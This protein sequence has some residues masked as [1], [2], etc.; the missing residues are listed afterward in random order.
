[1]SPIQSVPTQTTAAGDPAADRRLNPAITTAG[2]DYL[3]SI[4]HFAGPAANAI[5][6]RTAFGARTYGD[7]AAHRPMRELIGEQI[8][9]ADDINGW[10]IWPA[11]IAASI[12]SSDERYGHGR[13]L[14]DQ[15]VAI[16]R[17]AVELRQM[18]TRAARH[19]E[20]HGLG[21][22]TLHELQTAAE[23]EDLAHHQAA[24]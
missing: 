22:L 14:T 17:R 10:G 18:L 4:D 24:A 15:L 13:D 8:E 1:M 9:E 16:G 7:Q 20:R 3:A 21:D 6:R 5:R 2:R 23:Q 12:P 19:A 11:S